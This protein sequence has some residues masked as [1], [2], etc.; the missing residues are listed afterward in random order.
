MRILH[1]I[2]QGLKM[3]AVVLIA[4]L[5]YGL[6]MTLQEDHLIWKDTLI[7]A[8]SFFLLFGMFFSIMYSSMLYNQDIPLVISFGATRREAFW[9]LQLGR[10]AYS[11][12]MVLIA[13]CFF[14][15]AS[16]I[17]FI[18]LCKI[19][20]LALAGFLF[21]H[22]LGAIMAILYIKFQKKGVIAFG[23]ALM[24]IFIG[25]LAGFILAVNGDSDFE[26]PKYTYYLAV[27][28]GVLAYGLISMWEHRIVRN[29]N[30]KL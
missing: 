10:A 18:D 9:G 2:K 11:V 14:L 16:E 24:C 21:C 3:V 23:T 12:P 30:V 25:G 5:F 19:A 7:L 4:C 29:Y 13:G 22:T 27:G 1:W 17:S 26:L 8:G 6:M 15:I 20:P 28:A